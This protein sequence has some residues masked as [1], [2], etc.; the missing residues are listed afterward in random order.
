MN[1][2]SNNTFKREGIYQY[3]DRT[4]SAISEA[5]EY[6]IQIANKVYS[7]VTQNTALTILFILIISQAFILYRMNDVAKD[8]MRVKN[9]S[10]LSEEM[11]GVF[12]KILTHILQ[13]AFDRLVLDPK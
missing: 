9:T 4:R 7:F 3:A 8:L 5:K 11:I 2:I 10:R 6:L 1:T 13:K 12:P